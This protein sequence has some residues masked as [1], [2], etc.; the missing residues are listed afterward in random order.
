MYVRRS[1]K[2]AELNGGET[3]GSKE[4]TETS[5]DKIKCEKDVQKYF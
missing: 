3:S 4:G 5:E 1:D 2:I